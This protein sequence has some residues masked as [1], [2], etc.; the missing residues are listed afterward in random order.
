MAKSNYIVALIVT[1]AILLLV[2]FYIKGLEDSKFNELNKELDT[3]VL[4]NTLFS[5]YS[6]FDL[7][8]KDA[9]CAVVSQ[10][11]SNLSKRASSLEQRL[12]GYKESSFNSEEFILTKRNYLMANMFLYK[13]YA[14]AKDRCD[15]NT[16]LVLFFYAEDN[17][18]GSDCGV[19]GT[20]LFAL[21]QN[22][23]SFKNFNFPYNSPL[24]EFTKIIE[25]KYG[26]DKS[27]TY[28][29]DGKKYVGAM[30]NSEFSSLLGCS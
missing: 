14:A 8:N 22:C 30:N 7:E 5:A 16:K 13:S 6:D 19:I 21:A 28:V 18:C 23:S 25:A 9:Y 3:I 17:S 2:F 12:A 11:I 29:I 15:L 10:G 27:A 26:V 24:Y 1:V 4:E 20:Q